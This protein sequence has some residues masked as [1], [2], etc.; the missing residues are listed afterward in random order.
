LIHCFFV[1]ILPL[2]VPSTQPDVNPT[3]PHLPFPVLAPLQKHVVSNP[4]SA[5]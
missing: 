1:P 3:T 2:L 5:H 4:L